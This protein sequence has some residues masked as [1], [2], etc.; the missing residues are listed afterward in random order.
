[1]RSDEDARR[2]L[3]IDR[4]LY[5]ITNA[6]LVNA[7]H[8]MEYFGEQGQGWIKVDSPEFAKFDPEMK[9]R[10]DAAEWRR[11]QEEADARRL[12]QACIASQRAAAAREVERLRLEEEAE[13][14][15]SRR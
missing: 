5:M 6:V 15:I 10:M 7:P 2:Y 8:I 9:A 14:K 1:M 13:L 12:E 4:V 11:Q 3:G